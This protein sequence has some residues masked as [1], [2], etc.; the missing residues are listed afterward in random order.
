VSIPSSPSAPKISVGIGSWTDAEYKGLLYPKGLPDDERLKT[1][2]S[3]FSHVEVNA[4]S[5]APPGRAKVEN[6]LK[7]T[8]A[9][10]TFD[11]KLHQDFALGPEAAVR[12]GL[13]DR[14]LG[15]LKVMIEAGK[16]GAFLLL[17]PSTFTPKGNRLEAFDSVVEKFAPHP[18]AVEVRHR[19]WLEGEQRAATLEYFRTRKLTLVSVDMPRIDSPKIMP[20]VDEITNPALAYLRLHGRNPDWLKLKTQ[21]ERH[22]YEYRDEELS[23][24]AERVRA[25]AKQAEQVRVVANNHASDFAPKTALA[26]QRW[27]GLERKAP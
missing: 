10:F 16:F 4:T 1:Y 7:Q 2:A 11:I 27:L 3:W 24:I 17:L 5:Y 8:P 20:A 19:A 23:E 25:L 26:L 6:W 9:G 18:I 21:G 15:D 14:F 22:A 12:R 13:G